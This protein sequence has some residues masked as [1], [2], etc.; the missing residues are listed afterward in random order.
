MNRYTQLDYIDHRTD[1]IEYQDHSL[2]QSLTIL[3]Y[4]ARQTCVKNS[5]GKLNSFVPHFIKLS[6]A[7]HEL[8]CKQR[9]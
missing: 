2:E 6:A 9:K 7:V 5:E 3:L 4:M 8:S 1:P